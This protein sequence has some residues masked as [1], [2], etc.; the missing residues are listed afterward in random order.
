MGGATRYRAPLQTLC[1][2][3]HLYKSNQHF[4]S[5]LAAYSR[6]RLI[7][8][9]RKSHER[10]AVVACVHPASLTAAEPCMVR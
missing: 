9:S 10:D 1:P 2:Y 6:Q 5:I 3:T 8:I 7:S 4:L